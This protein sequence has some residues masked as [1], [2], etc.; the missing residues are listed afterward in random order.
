MPLLLVHLV[1]K[2]VFKASRQRKLWGGILLEDLHVESVGSVERSQGAISGAHLGQIAQVENVPLRAS[3]LCSQ[4]S[5]C[6]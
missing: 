3:A 6:S 1:L 5:S 2:I 4:R